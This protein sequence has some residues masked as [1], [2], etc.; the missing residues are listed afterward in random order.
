MQEALSQG[1]SRQN[2]IEEMDL[3][4]AAS[5]SLEEFAQEQDEEAFEA[6]RAETIALVEDHT[7]NAQSIARSGPT[8]QGAEKTLSK[9]LL[10]PC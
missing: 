8:S 10:F 1:P 7:Q 5:V 2:F 6:T 4:F 9:V 3:Q